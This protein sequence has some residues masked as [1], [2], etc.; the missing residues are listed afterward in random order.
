MFLSVILPVYNERN[1][2]EANVDLLVAYLSKN[3][4]SFEIIIVEDDSPDGSYDTALRIA[5]RY[6][7]IV[8]LHNDYRIGRGASVALAMKKA[9]GD[10]VVYMDA[11]LATDIRYTKTL[12]DGLVSGASITTGSRLMKSSRAKRPASRNIASIAYNS[13]VRLIFG[14]KLYDHQC[15]FKGFNKKDVLGMID[16][17]QDGHWFWDTELLILCQNAGLKVYEFPVDWVHNGGNSLANSK[18]H[19]LTD[20]FSMAEHILKFK[21]RLLKNSNRDT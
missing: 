15:G 6:K 4:S 1:R 19:V 17:V 16:L 8:L 9:R 2:L 21:Y 20:S 10:Y 5:D 12:V 14:S 3:F 7:N 18:V 13:L 11:D